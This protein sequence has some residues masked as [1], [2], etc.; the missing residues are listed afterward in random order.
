MLLVLFNSGLF[1]SPFATMC[2]KGSS[3]ITNLLRLIPLRTRTQKKRK[4]KKSTLRS[5]F[6]DLMDT[7]VTQRPLST[8]DVPEFCP[9]NQIDHV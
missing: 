8:Q 1:E 4:K 5:E 2:S 6:C 3:S 9:Q 7:R